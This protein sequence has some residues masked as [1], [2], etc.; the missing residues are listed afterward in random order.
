MGK[1]HFWTDNKRYGSAAIRPSLSTSA[2]PGL[3]IDVK[4]KPKSNTD[5][6]RREPFQRS[7]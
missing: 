3:N 2:G 7:Y 6:K 1:N 5:Q 4:W